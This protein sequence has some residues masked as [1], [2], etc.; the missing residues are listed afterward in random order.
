M[1]PQKISLRNEYGKAR[2][3]ND[4]L[5]PTANIVLS[6]SRDALNDFFSF[7]TKSSEGDQ[8]V[9]LFK[10]SDGIFLDFVHQINS[11]SNGGMFSLTLLDPAGEFLQALFS[12]TFEDAL[13]EIYKRKNE[14]P[15]EPTAVNTKEVLTVSPSK[16]RDFTR[17]ERDAIVSKYS[18]TKVYL[19]YGLGTESRNWAGPFVVNI[20]NAFYSEGLDSA[21]K[22]ELQFVGTDIVGY[23]EAKPTSQAED[24]EVFKVE[25]P[26]AKVVESITGLGTE[27][28]PGEDIPF[29]SVD[30]LNE[31]M[32][33]DDTRFFEVEND[34][35][36][37]LQRILGVGESS[38]QG[39][40]TRLTDIELQY[41][42]VDKQAPLEG[43]VY[44][45]LTKYLK[46]LGYANCIIFLNSLGNDIDL[47]DEDLNT[48]PRFGKCRYNKLDLKREEL[49][50]R[51]MTSLGFELGD[52]TDFDDVIETYKESPVSSEL[53]QGGQQSFKSY[54]LK[55]A[56][57]VKAKSVNDQF[58][59][60]LRFLK[61]YKSNL[62]D[63]FTTRLTIENNLDKIALLNKFFPKLVPDPTSP[64]VIVGDDYLIQA[65]LYAK[66]DAASVD[67]K[68]GDSED[69]HLTYIMSNLTGSYTKEMRNIVLRKKA[70]LAFFDFKDATGKGNPRIPDDFDIS[71]ED[72]QQ[73]A[74]L[75]IPVFRAN[76]E[77]PNVL[78]FVVKNQSLLLSTYSNTIR[79][80]VHFILDSSDTNEE[81]LKK[82]DVKKYIDDMFKDKSRISKIAGNLGIQMTD[83]DDLSQKLF[84]HLT[85][86]AFIGLTYVSES[87]PSVILASYIENFY[88]LFSKPY[89]ANLRTLPYF[90]LSEIDLINDFCLLFKNTVDVEM[91]GSDNI[92]N[93]IYSGFWRFTGFKHVIGEN[94][95]Y[96]EFT[97]IKDPTTSNILSK[98]LGK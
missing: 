91:F 31:I 68:L 78:S 15:D 48:S 18:S 93:S 61:N 90:N 73:A 65:L 27:L 67:V 20:S 42:F 88:K 37:L 13:K 23:P 94:D 45:L 86:P 64:V 81:S 34:D 59:P 41:D 85:D 9:Y 8:S 52:Q 6:F 40:T 92:V 72:Q 2:S 39:E 47:S 21:N 62:Q 96:S 35:P 10:P 87:A 60:L 71:A 51:F 43:P 17:E 75:G 44:R 83:T 50:F 58:F 79:Q 5:V 3:N 66:L 55:I 26:F 24:Y 98:D 49:S 29:Q 14:L 28:T 89:I 69:H 74:E 53:V 30:A 36:S 4:N 11:G 57:D 76:T 77:N 22:L 32:G 97:V 25:E 56:N 33:T 63:L 70:A 80:L 82:E 46:K 1:S 19:S 12:Y 84:N 95:A 38:V 54:S 16:K 7:G